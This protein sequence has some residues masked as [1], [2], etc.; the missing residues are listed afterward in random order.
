VR[1]HYRPSASI[2]WSAHWHQEHP[3][4]GINPHAFLA[5]VWSSG[6]SV[7]SDCSQGSREE[8]KRVVLRLRR[9]P[10][11]CPILVRIKW[12]Y[13]C[14]IARTYCYMMSW[15]I[16]NNK[17]ASWRRKRLHLREYK[18]LDPLLE[19]LTRHRTLDN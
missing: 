5:I 11:L 14:L 4:Q 2:L 19:Q 16:V 1:T 18:A 13:D 3:N 8:G 10:L 9:K 6:S 17:D 12:Y 7:R 15:A